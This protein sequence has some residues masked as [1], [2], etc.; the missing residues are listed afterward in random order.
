M[1]IHEVILSIGSNLGDRFK[2]IDQSVAILQK[3]ARIE[4]VEVSSYLENEAIGFESNHLFINVCVLIKTSIPPF[5]L[6][7]LL[8]SIE[9]EIGRSYSKN[10][11]EDRLIDMDIIFYSDFEIITDRLTIPH[12]K[13]RERDFVIFPLNEILKS[14]SFSFSNYIKQNLG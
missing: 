8:K 10:G 3:D 2:N 6:L 4:L 13:F 9:K 7:T 11:Y 14:T 5:D 12:R 1:E